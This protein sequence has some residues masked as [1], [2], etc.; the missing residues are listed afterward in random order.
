VLDDG[1]DK[2]LMIIIQE[3]AVATGS[4]LIELE[5]MPDNVHLLAEVGPQYIFIAW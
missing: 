5:I 2:R 3:V 1:V 4:E